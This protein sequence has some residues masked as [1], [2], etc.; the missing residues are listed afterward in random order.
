[1]R[2]IRIAIPA[3]ILAFAAAGCILVS[4]QFLLDFALDD[5]TASTEL[6]VTRTDID[7][8]TESDYQD[9]KDDLKSIA[10]IAVL[11]KITNN[12]SAAVGAEVWM[13]PS[14][15]TVYTTADDVK[16]HATRLWGPLTVQPGA[17]NAVT[18]DWNKSAQLFST[19]GKALLLDEA[20]GD[21]QFTLYLIGDTTTYNIDVEN[22]VLAIV[23]DFGK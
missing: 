22:G 15:A 3:V 7:L 6:T 2:T 14:N 17:S 19:T 12:G 21:G 20:K 16:T 10:D 9:H 13:T 23:L 5:F 1:M 8:T 4:G 18:V 11:G